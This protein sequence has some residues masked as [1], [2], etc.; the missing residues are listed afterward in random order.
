MSGRGFASCVRVSQP[1][2]DDSLLHVRDAAIAG[3]F[4]RLTR[5]RAP[6]IVCGGMKILVI[7]GGGREH[8]LVWKLRQS[9]RVERIWC[10]PGNG[11]IAQDAECRAVD[12]KDVGAILSLAERLKPDLTVVGPE[13]PLV[14]GV[15]D[16]FERRGMRVI[17]PSKQAAQLEGSKVFAK[18][19]MERHGIPTASV[20][21]VHDSPGDAYSALCAVDW[22]A[23]IKADG[24]CGGKGVL[25]TSSPDEA[26]AFIER[27]MEKREFG[28]SGAR[29]LMEEALE[30]EELS[31][32]VLTDGEY[33]LPLVPTRDHKRVFDGNEGPNTGGMGA[34]S[35]DDL[36]PPLLEKTI[37]EVIAKPTIR[38]LAAEGRP[39]KGFLYFGL[40][41]TRD[42]P[43]VLEFNCR[44]GDPEAQPIVVRMGFDLVE[45]FEGVC[46]GNLDKVKA[47][48]KGVASV[49]VVM[50]SGGYPG[51][52]ETGKRIEGVESVSGLADVVVFHAG[53]RLDGAIY[54]TSG[55]RVLGV[56][57]AELAL[58]AAIHSCYE[59]VSKIRFEGA[60][61]RKDIGAQWL[62]RTRAA[63]D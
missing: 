15:A 50:A 59:A 61:Y 37:L 33:I 34:Y 18:E 42:G 39:Y 13:L 55:G 54:Y 4:V 5:E 53:S 36:V 3:R 27:L 16:E 12:V 35:T 19:F 7:G 32:I 62:S 40:M 24:L 6:T 45:A 14:L 63:G 2:T 57:A 21:G 41:L 22:P 52:F 8:A 10:A 26:T 23:V 48:W 9:P 44:M 29:V 11:G 60:H 56:T 58:E 43:K 25:V 51:R 49:C 31:F 1:K 38:A 30:G 17:G 46:G 28:E 20:Y 47:S